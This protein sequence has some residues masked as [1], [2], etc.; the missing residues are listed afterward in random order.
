M[1]ILGG[2]V[3][4][5][6]ALRETLSYAATKQN[7]SLLIPELKLTGDNAVMIGMAAYYHIQN[8]DFVEPFNLRADPQWELV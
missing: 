5:N 2:G 8:K 6:S 4:A 7:L 1:V 3:S